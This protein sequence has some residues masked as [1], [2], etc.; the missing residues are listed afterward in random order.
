MALTPAAIIGALR[1][2]APDFVG[3]T[4]IFLFNAIG[5]AVYSWAIV[6]ANVTIAGVTTGTPGS[7]LVTGTLTVPP[8]PLL[9]VNVFVAGG[10]AG[11]SGVSLARAVGVGIPMAFTTTAQYFGASV[12]VGIG[13]DVS[14]V[15]AVNPATLVPLLLSNMQAN[16]G[17]VLGP[18]APQT[19]NAI[20]N[21]VASLLI[22]GFGAGIVAPTGTAPG[23]AVGTS[24][25][26]AVI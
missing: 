20:S 22:A 12:G 25:L 23:S 5:V 14:K 9:A 1:T 4:S 17:G 26:S 3:P 13:S 7:G 21:A 15:V 6:P 10:V 16:F 11:P 24:P 8:N 19:A 2:A 18:S